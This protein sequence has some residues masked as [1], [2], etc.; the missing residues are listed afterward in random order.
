MPPR[1]IQP[2]LPI[3]YVSAEVTLGGIRGLPPAVKL[4]SAAV[5]AYLLYRQLHS[6]QGRVPPAELEDALRQIDDGGGGV[7]SS[8]LSQIVAALRGAN[9][10]GISMHLKSTPEPALTLGRAR[11]LISPDVLPRLLEDFPS[12]EPAVRYAHKVAAMVGESVRSQ[13]RQTIA[14]EI[15]QLFLDKPDVAIGSRLDGH[16]L[17]TT[18]NK[19]TAAA[20]LRRAVRCLSERED[21]G[22]L[23]KLHKEQE[24]PGDETVFHVLQ[25][26]DVPLLVEGAM[27]DFPN[28][29]GDRVSLCVVTEVLSSDKR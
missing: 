2:G 19:V 11:G 25:E 29:A 16:I 15:T 24:K 27:Y 26:P 10:S 8:P 17:H 21:V 5:V 13:P 12:I 22:R 1:E 9:V 6:S 20:A 28:L 18:R 7:N 23:Y 14:Q 3:P 4:G